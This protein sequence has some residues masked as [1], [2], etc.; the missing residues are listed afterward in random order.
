MW[1][2]MDCAI[3]QSDKLKLI[4]FISSSDMYTCGK[5]VE[6][7]ENK[8]SEWLGCKHSLFVTSGSTANLLLLASIKEFYNIPNGSKVLVPAC[9]WVTNVSPVFQN[10]LEPVFCDI[11]LDNYSF[12]TDN[13]PDD[14]IKI[15]FITHL[16]GL[17]APMEK[18]KNKYQ[19]AIFIEDICESHGI[20]DEYGKKRGYGT[21]STFSFYYGHHMTTIEGGMISTDNAELYQL[22]KLK[23]SHGM[24]RH[25]LSENYE[26]TVSKY[27]NIDPKFLFLTD[28]YN[29][30]NTEL[31]AVIGIEQLQRLDESIKI[32]KRNYDRFMVQLLK[33]ETFFHVPRYDPYNSSFCLPFV[34]KTSELKTKLVNI[35]N[36]LEIEYRPIVGGNL[37]I[38]PFLTKWK[39]STK[40]PNADLLND[41]GVYIGNSQFVTLE[42]IDKAF[43]HIKHICQ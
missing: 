7:F 36:K 39:N 31:N 30:R 33:Y 14:D 29:F 21:G 27:P 35:F 17:N 10:G 22:M 13:L 26:K 4:E 16:L 3:T 32:R 42:M 12:D 11:N 5:K 25:L 18:L 28:G 20:T 41:N 34:C 1:K 9:T 23:R 40:T 43:E 8:W 19:D 15:V 37:L 24:A 38:H 6:E 2:L